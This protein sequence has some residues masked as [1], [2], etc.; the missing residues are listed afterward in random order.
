VRRAGRRGKPGDSC[1]HEHGTGVSR[2]RNSGR[3]SRDP[4]LGLG[5]ALRTLPEIAGRQIASPMGQAVLPPRPL[6]NADRHREQ[7]LATAIGDRDA[8]T[9]SGSPA[10]RHR[11][12]YGSASRRLPA[13]SGRG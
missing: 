1:R 13:G 6:A 2:P 10:R 5:P 4:P 9:F 12:L 3:L 7:H 8:D 11:R